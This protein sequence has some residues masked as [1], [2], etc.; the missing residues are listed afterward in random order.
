[1]LYALILLAATLAVTSV[2]CALVIRRLRER[3]A[4]TTRTLKRS[5]AGKVERLSGLLEDMAR[6]QNEIRFQARLL[7]TVG[8][9]VLAVD[10]AGRVVYCNQA[11]GGLFGRD[12]KDAIGATLDHVVPDPGGAEHALA[13][14]RA[15]H[16]WTGELT[17]RLPDGSTVPILMTD[18][19]VHDE[20]GRLSG[21]VRVAADLTSR[22][23]AELASR[24]L[25]DASA[26]L[27]ASL[28]YNATARAVARLALPELADAC[29]VDV[30]GEGGRM[31]RIEAANI[32][33][34]KEQLAREMSRRYPLTL[35]ADHPIC[36]VIRTGR[37]RLIAEVHDSLVESIAR[38][39]EH[40]RMLHELAYR[41]AIIVPLVAGGERFG[42]ISFLTTS[43]GRYYE[44][45]DLA[46]AEELARRAAIALEHARLYETSLLANQAK[47]DFLAVV[48]HELRTPLT[49]I[50][51]YA[52]LLLSGLPEALPPKSRTH[53]E[54]V[55]NAAWHLLG[56]IEQILVYSRLEA[57]REQMHP[58]RVSVSDLL[59]AT[60]ALIEPFA[61]ERGLHFSVDAANVPATIETDLTK[62]RQILL[63]LLSNAVK[64]TDTGEVTLGA[65]T[66]RNT[67][68][69][70]VRDTGIGIAEEHFENV[71]DPF[72]QVDQSA[73]RSVGGTGL[74]L[75]VSRKLARLL[76][77][78]ITVT[79]IPGEGAVF[80]LRL[81]VHW[82]P[83][84]L[85]SVREPPTAAGALRA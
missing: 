77:G 71:F 25:A 13:R 37:P 84:G 81:P 29:A 5:H 80:S 42:A 56:L 4:H 34:D 61:A 28:D 58:E 23:R 17:V 18:S 70:T 19:P 22:K 32:D 64:F 26:A 21:M 45:R 62:V 83:P 54:R 14:L 1:M 67:V 55:R 79:S 44:E 7:D 69:F 63:N 35:D 40:L 11:A 27:A 46:L 73:T 16:E 85:E 24:I 33:R 31:W 12:A 47:S 59:A 36:D 60:A 78:D 52:D 68:M 39:D 10:L 48:S 53:V 65:R 82:T 6:A 57:G 76:G 3:L 51:G 72:W 50:M 30:T 66:D 8:Q 43:S 15:G 49:T 38:D 74:G 2:A 9:A 20:R 75:A 41:S